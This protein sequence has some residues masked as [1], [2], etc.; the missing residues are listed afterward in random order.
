LIDQAA[1]AC[2]RKPGC[3]RN[4][5]IVAGDISNVAR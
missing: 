3:R 2:A 1:T 4:E 5:L